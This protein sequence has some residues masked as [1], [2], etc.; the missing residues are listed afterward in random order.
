MIEVVELTDLERLGAIG[1]NKPNGAHLSYAVL[2]D[3]IRRLPCP[4]V[5]V[6]EPTHLLR[7]E[8]LEDESHDKMLWALA[9]DILTANL[10]A[11]GIGVIEAD[12]I[13]TLALFGCKLERLSVGA[14]PLWQTLA[15]EKLLDTIYIPEDGANSVHHTAMKRHANALKIRIVSYRPKLVTGRCNMPPRS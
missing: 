15:S 5:Y 2:M 3:I 13:R 9:Y 8:S 4:R 14:D 7:N 11:E 10:Q 6:S 1:P 12:T